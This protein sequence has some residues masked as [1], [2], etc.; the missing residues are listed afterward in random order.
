MATGETKSLLTV[1]R[2]LCSI[3]IIVSINFS[4]FQQTLTFALPTGISSSIR[5]QTLGTIFA[6]SICFSFLPLFFTRTGLVQSPLHRHR[7][8]E[9]HPFPY[10]QFSFLYLTFF[11]FGCIK[12]CMK[13][14]NLNG[15][16]CWWMHF[17]GYFSLDSVFR[18]LFFC[19]GSKSVSIA[20][21]WKKSMS[22]STHNR[23]KSKCDFWLKK[24]LLLL[25]LF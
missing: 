5:V 17:C 4:T 11:N 20:K 22:S 19:F 15:T 24:M 1:I 3:S 2:F 21:K 13:P 12:P 10:V 9:F 14:S 8:D 18:G 25:T 23:R 6:C 16:P 7:L